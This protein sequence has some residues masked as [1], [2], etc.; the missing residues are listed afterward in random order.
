MRRRLILLGTLAAL[1]ALLAAC[2][3]TGSGTPNTS[4]GLDF[5]NFQ[6]ASVVIGQANFTTTSSTTNAST[7]NTVYGDPAVVNGVFYAPDYND[8]RILGFTGGVP[9]SNGAAADFVLGQPDFTTTNF[10]A[11]ANGMS[12]PQTVTEGN[13]RL[14]NVDYDYNRVLIWDTPPTTTHAPADVVVGQQDFTS[15]ATGCTATG[16]DSP[17]SI[18][19]TN[20]KLIVADTA[21]NRVLIFNTLPTAN[22][23]AADLVLGQNGFTTCAENDDNQDGVADVAP[24]ARTL[25]EPSDVWTDG[26]MLIVADDSNNRVLI[27]NTFPTSSFAPADVV[28]GQTGMNG[29]GAG[30]SATQFDDPYFLTS[31]GKQLFV[32]EWN[33]DRVVVFDPIPTSNGAAATTVLGQSDFAHNTCND[34][35]QDGAIDGQ[36]SA[37][38]L[39]NPSGLLATSNAL[40]VVDHD[41][42]RMLVF[43]P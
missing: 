40:I 27:W 11:A 15:T 14:F 8:G 32:A 2:S 31:N 13:G 24:T 9:S 37:R 18:A 42:Q 43:K 25:Y 6:Q 7:F 23:A 34:D 19:T 33:N 30:T 38:T 21:N 17:E 26:T 41:N 1:A 10:V 12:G 36:P 28:V 5:S 22:G 16:L 3:Q 35:N 20:S 29:N 39:C 4:N